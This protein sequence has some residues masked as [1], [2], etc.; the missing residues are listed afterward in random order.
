[1]IKKLFF[2][3]S[4]LAGHTSFARAIDPKELKGPWREVSRIQ[5]G[6]A[7]Q[8]RDTLFFEVLS[9]A[10]CVWGKTGPEAPRLKMKLTGTTLEI[11]SYEFDIMELDGDRMRLSG[12][13]GVEMELQRYSKRPLLVRTPKKPVNTNN[14]AFRPAAIPKTGNVPAKI[15]PFVG[16]WKCYKRSSTKPIDTANKYRIIRLI[17]ILEL[18]SEQIVGKVYGFDDLEATPSWIVQQYDKGILYTSGKDERN[19]RVINCQPNELVIENEGVVYYMN[20]M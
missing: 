13:E 1:M 6:K 18:D 15:E 14:V 19:F 2:L 10:M 9:S 20:K 11:G 3:L 5:G 7:V 8:F 16:S 12:Q 17:E 4:L